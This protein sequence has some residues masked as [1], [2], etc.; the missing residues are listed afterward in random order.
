MATGYGMDSPG[1]IH[2][3]KIFLFSTESRTVLEPTQ[4]PIKRV[5]GATPRG[6]RG[7]GVKLTTH[8]HVVLYLHHTCHHGMGLIN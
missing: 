5:P 8:L 1:T 4:S 6:Q 3:Y 2:D 7:R